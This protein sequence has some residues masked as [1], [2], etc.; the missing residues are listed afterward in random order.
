VDIGAFLPQTMYELPVQNYQSSGPEVHTSSLAD[1]KPK[2]KT[3]NWFAAFKNRQSNQSAV[4][5]PVCPAC[6]TVKLAP[7]IDLS[8]RQIN[9]LV[10]YTIKKLN[11]VSKPLHLS[12][13]P[14][15]LVKFALLVSQLHW[16][17]S[18]PLKKLKNKEK[19]IGKI[20]SPS[21]KFAE[22]AK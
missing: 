19:N 7:H 3:E 6:C 10:Q 14:E 4:D 13:N 17:E 18:R 22:R 20:Y 15:I 8:C 5:L 2:I 21:G 9:K 11:E 12:T 1:G 16:L